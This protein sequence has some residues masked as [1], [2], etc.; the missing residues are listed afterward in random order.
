MLKTIKIAVFALTLA[1]ASCQSEA[2]NNYKLVNVTTFETAIKT[3][4]A[5]ILDV[6][7]PAEFSKGAI[8]NAQ[9]IDWNGADFVQKV[10]KLDKNQ[11]VYVY[12]LSGGRSKKASDK[13]VNLGFKNVI[14]LEGGYM[15][16]SKTHA[17]PTQKSQYTLDQY[18]KMVNENPVVLIDFYAEWCG[19]CKKMAP[20]IEQFK[21][22][23]DGKVKIIKIDADQNKQLVLD[24][25]YQALPIILVYK[26]GQKV[27]ERE[28]FVS[29]ADLKAT[30]DQQL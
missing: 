11:P 16:W 9:N 25:G 1:V 20:Y 12:C 27:F 5:Q 6:R 4:N 8:N 10:E 3:P 15:N 24:L 13:L 19:P 14:E 30:L 7:T 22:D 18:N 21:T 17:T 23:Y 28:G 29:Q 26:N 2:Q